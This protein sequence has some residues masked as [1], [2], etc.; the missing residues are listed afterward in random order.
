[1]PGVAKMAQKQRKKEKNEKG[2]ISG[3]QTEN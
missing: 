1:M 2:S 3:K